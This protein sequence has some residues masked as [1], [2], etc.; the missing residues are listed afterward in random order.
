RHKIFD[1]AASR[2][3]LR[4]VIAVGTAAK[5]SVATWVQ[6]HGGAADPRKL[7]EADGD[8]IKS[9]LRI[10]GVLHPGSATSGTGPI[11]ADFKAALGR[12]DGWIAA[13]PRWLPIDPDGQRQPASA[14]EYPNAT[15]PFLDVT[16]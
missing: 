11:I 10:V 3:D 1:L 4:L 15:I 12:I 5:E 8:A 2:H 13:D 7:H 16:F 9:G 6:S 14:F